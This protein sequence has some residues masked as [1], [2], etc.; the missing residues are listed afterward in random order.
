MLEEMRYIKLPA[1]T[2]RTIANANKLH[3]SLDGLGAP[4]RHF[5][6]VN[7]A[8]FVSEIKKR[9]ILYN[10]THQDYRRISLRNDAWIEVALAMNLSEQECKKRWRS[11]RDA[12]I[13][14]VRNKNETER[15]AW[16]HYRLLEFMLPYLSSRKEDF[17][18]SNECSQCIE[19]DE[20]IDYLEV[21][22]DDELF[23]GTIAVSY[24]THDGKEVFQVMHAPIKQEMPVE[25]ETMQQDT[26][27]EIEDGN[28]EEEEQEQLQPLPY[29]PL[30]GPEYL[31]ATTTDDEAEQDEVELYEEQQPQHNDYPLEWHTEHLESD[32]RE[33]D[34][35]AELNESLPSKRLKT[36]LPSASVSIASSSSPSPVTVQQEAA[37][38]PLAQQQP[39]PP[40]P[41]PPPVQQE[42][43]KESDARL[44]I[45]DPDERFLLS[46][47]PILRRLPNKK[48]L[49]ARLRIQQLLF[50]LEYDEKYCYEGT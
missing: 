4:K 32:G 27:E 1:K 11:M 16:I 3:F 29:S 33:M 35:D 24:V 37:V 49:L 10:T 45:T 40:P 48:N 21:D 17:E 36:E 13:K 20:E 38:P 8:E 34:D 25:D 44:G 2:Y 12:F 7:V 9:P 50:E 28:E 18:A 30:P 15:K 43:S 41:P 42:E 6:K 39:S 26:E 19:N 22:S 47:A 23:D 5:V 31:L 14:T 46:C